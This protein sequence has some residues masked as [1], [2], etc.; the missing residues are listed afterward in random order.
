MRG[1]GLTLA[2]REDISRGIAAGCSGRVIA[3][4]LGRDYGVVNREI[5]RCGGRQG[6]RAYVA[7]ERAVVQRARPKRRKLESCAQLLAMVNAGFQQRWS[8]RQISARLAKDHL[9]EPW[10]RV[11]HEAIYQ[12]L[13]CQARGA[14]RA[15][16]KGVLRRGGTMRLSRAQRAV[17]IAKR[18][19]IPDK[20]M[21]SQRPPEAD[22]RAVP[23]HWEGDLIMGARNRSAII[24]LVE[25]TT[26]FVILQR[27][28]Y[29]HNADR[30]ALLLTQAM[31]RLP[32]LLRRSLTWDQGREMARHARFTIATGIPVFFAD[33]HSPW[34]RGSNENTN[35]LLR[36]FFPKGTD[37]SI[38]SQTDLDNV[39][40]LLNG[41]PRQTLDFDTPTERLDKL[42]TEAGEAL[43]G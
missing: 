38:H 8:P 5:A 31:G 33:P 24:T 13:Y 35:G 11:S 23:G 22:E 27:V 12:A 29:D 18:E 28:P 42:L 9:H 21:I 17:I 20:I 19:A 1:R 3:A 7:H 36:E 30:V 4:G 6:Y 25:R 15:E 37:L 14:L 43:T 10:L 34:Q 26:R 32:H 2:E 39:A 16:L 41:R 40:Y